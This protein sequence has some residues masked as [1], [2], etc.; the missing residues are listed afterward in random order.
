MAYQT[1]R[2][3]YLN[4]PPI[5]RVYTTACV[6]TTLAVVSTLIFLIECMTNFIQYLLC[7]LDVCSLIVLP[8]NA[9]TIIFPGLDTLYLRILNTC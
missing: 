6:V 3:E 1:L 2:N 7:S 9:R 5:T 8:S 4:T